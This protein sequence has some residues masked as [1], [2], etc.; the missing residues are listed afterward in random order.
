MLRGHSSRDPH[1]RRRYLDAGVS[2]ATVLGEIYDRLLRAY[3]PQ[4]WW[5]ADSP[6]EVMVGAVLTQN[7]SWTNVA[8]AID[9]LEAAGALTPESISSLPEER[10]AQLVYSSGYYNSKAKKLKALVGFLDYRSDGWLEALSREDD[11]TLRADL[12]AV[13]GIGEET[14][15]DILLYAVGKPFFVIDAY[16]RRTFFR[17]G[18]AP[19]KAKY[20]AYQDIFHTGLPRD[21]ALSGSTTPSSSATPYGRAT[22]R[23]YATSVRCW[24]CVRLD[25]RTL[26]EP[27]TTLRPEPNPYRPSR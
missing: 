11:N 10:I 15:D 19:E 12:L 6:F 13:H 2:G 20:A 1:S 17:L 26:S 21:A 25:A 16:T 24:T 3:G 23:R 9:E 22:R 4:S 5:P 8:T 7:T 18:L 14:A 27:R